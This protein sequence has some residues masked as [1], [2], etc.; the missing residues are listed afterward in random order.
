M[1]LGIE[2][3]KSVVISVANILNA[4][5]GFVHKQ[6]LLA[7]YPVIAE[8]QALIKL[9]W[10]VVLE[11]IKDLSA[12]E[13]KDLEASFLGALQLQNPAVQV[14]LSEAIDCVQEGAAVLVSGIALIN[15][16]KALV[17]A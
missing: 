8:A 9:D 14:K 16:L 3:L 13:G 2:K 15:K 4:V 1:A 17:S 10:K 5:S 7:L 6:G 11:E 12:E